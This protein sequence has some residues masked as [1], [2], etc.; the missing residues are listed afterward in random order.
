MLVKNIGQQLVGITAG[1]ALA[2][3][4]TASVTYAQSASEV[5]LYQ[6]G[7]NAGMRLESEG[8]TLYNLDD[9]PYYTVFLENGDIDT[10]SVDIPYTG[11][12]VLL[13]GGDDDTVDLDLYFPQIGAIDDTFGNTGLIEFSVTQPGEFVYDIDMLDCQA[14]NCGVYAVLLRISD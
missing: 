13:I 3:G 1:V 9:A 6:A 5:S 11:Q 2:I 14:A 12:Y 4:G 7:Y 8:Y 10:V